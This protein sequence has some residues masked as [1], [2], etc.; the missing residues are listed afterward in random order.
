[1]CCVCVMTRHKRRNRNKRTHRNKE[2]LHDMYTA[3]SFTLT[4]TPRT[5]IFLHFSSSYVAYQASQ[6]Y[7]SGMHEHTH[8]HFLSHPMVGTTVFSVADLALTICIYACVLPLIQLLLLPLPP[9]P[10]LLRL[11]RRPRPQVVLISCALCFK[12]LQKQ[13]DKPHLWLGPADA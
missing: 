9:R 3:S 10:R 1:M 8:A 13:K 2:N 6:N 12:C 4:I 7:I 5:H 11:P